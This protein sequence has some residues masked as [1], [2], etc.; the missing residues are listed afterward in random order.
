MLRRRLPVNRSRCIVLVAALVLFTAHARAAAVAILRPKSSAPEL[1]EALF[2][3]KGEL[4]A[5]GLGVTLAERPPGGDT[6]TP[7]ARAWLD[8]IAN[9][10]GF[11]AV[12]DVV[13][14]QKPVAVEVWLDERAPA[15]NESATPPTPRELTVT[16]V[17]LEPDTQNAAGTLAIRALEV[18][19]SKLVALD[20]TPKPPPPSA[21]V[22]ERPL[23]APKKPQRSA[24]FGLEAGLSV[25]MPRDGVGPLLL[26]LGRFD[27]AFRA[28]LALRVTGAAS[29]NRP[30]LETEAGVVHLAEQLGLLG[31]A[32]SPGSRSGIAPLLA[33][34]AGFL[35]TALDAEASLP[36]VGHRLEHWAFLIDGSVGA[37]AALSPHYF[38][39]LAAHVQ[40]A[41]PYAA[42]HVVDEVVTTI[43]RPSLL[44]TLTLGAWL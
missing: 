24:A 42:V 35:R 5:V 16:R 29:V 26:P 39:T 18:L 37:S 1:N 44:L 10:R 8:R 27:W 21:A 11:D 14:E 2:R 36:H 31:L 9:E 38:L 25:R 30:A 33:L 22:P 4:L 20:W 19:R 23:P 41:E 17:V 43:G 12:L 7:A 3:L 15:A 6:A 32:A 13:G 34:S 28:W 40:L